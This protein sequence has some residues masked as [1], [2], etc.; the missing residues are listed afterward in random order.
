MM[1][2]AISLILLKEYFWLPQCTEHLYI[3]I[4]SNVPPK[5]P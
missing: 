5:Y 3:K 4:E 2:W 1:F